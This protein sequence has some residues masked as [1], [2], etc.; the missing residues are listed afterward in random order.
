MLGVTYLDGGWS[1][2]VPVAGVIYTPNDDV[3]YQLV[4]P[5]PRVSWRLPSSPIP[6]RDERWVYVAVEYGN[7]AWAFQQPNGDARRARLSRLPR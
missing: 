6:G 1:K 4:F 2:V 5:T 3:E 7:A